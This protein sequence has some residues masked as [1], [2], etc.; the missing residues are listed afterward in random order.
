MI[1]EMGVGDTVG[2]SLLISQTNIRRL[3]FILTAIGP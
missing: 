3:N 1:K 2:R